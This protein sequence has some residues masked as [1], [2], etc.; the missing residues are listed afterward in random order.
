MKAWFETCK[1]GVE[2]AFRVK[3]IMEKGSDYMSCIG[4][5]CDKCKGIEVGGEGG[6]MVDVSHSA[7]ILREEEIL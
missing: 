1:S 5:H 6:K 4:K 7:V 3:L 2:V